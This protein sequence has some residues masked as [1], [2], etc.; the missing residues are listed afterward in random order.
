MS[1]CK[2]HFGNQADDQTA[3]TEST[4]DMSQ[5]NLID[6]INNHLGVDFDTLQVQVA[7]RKKD[8]A[9][10][11]RKHPHFQPSKCL[12]SSGSTTA[13]LGNVHHLMSDD[14]SVGGSLLTPRQKYMA[15]AASLGPDEVEYDGVTYKICMVE[16][17][18]DIPYISIS[19]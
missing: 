8:Q 13:H 14:N 10:S 9:I 18:S 5:P 16:L 11:Q 12:P 15:K 17:T 3:T 6:Y 4:G 1:V 7:A 19:F 2:V